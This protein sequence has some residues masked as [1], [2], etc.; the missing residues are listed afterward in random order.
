MAI[1]IVQFTHQGKQHTLTPIERRNGV[2]EW[3]TGEHRRK[4]MIA[5]GRYVLNGSKSLSGKQ[6]LLFWGEWEPMSKIEKTYHFKD[7]TVNPKYLHSPFLKINKKGI[8][9]HV[10]FKGTSK[11][12]SLVGGS[13]HVCSNYQNTDPFV[14]DDSF[15]YS[16]CKQSFKTMRQLDPGSIILFGSTILNTKNGGPYFALDTVFVVGESRDYTAGTY[17]TD[18]AGFIP[19]YYDQ[20]MGFSSWKN[21]IQP[22]TCYK[23]ASFNQPVEDMFSFVPCQVADN[24]LTG[25]PRV[26]LNQRQLCF[27]VDNLNSAPKIKPVSLASNKLAWDKICQIVKSQNFELGVRFWYK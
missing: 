20:I 18:L 15:F 4:F 6:D 5:E 1:Y 2:K 16:C 23:G 27:I 21:P 9:Q 14:F 19:P 26:I 12:A 22:Y 13:K 10:V 25:F 8:V 11:V 24:E 3:N 17:K 7:Y